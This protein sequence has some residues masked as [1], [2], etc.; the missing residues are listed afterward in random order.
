MNLNAIPRGPFSAD[1]LNEVTQ[2]LEMVNFLE[3]YRNDVHSAS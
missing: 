3:A 2:N 1:D